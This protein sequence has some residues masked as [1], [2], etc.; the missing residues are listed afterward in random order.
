MNSLNPHFIHFKC[1]LL[2]RGFMKALTFILNFKCS[3]V[4]FKFMK[5]HLHLKPLSVFMQT[6]T[7]ESAY[8]PLT[9]ALVYIW[10]HFHFHESA[11]I[12][13]ALTFFTFYITYYV[14]IG[15]GL[16]KPCKCATFYKV[17]YVNIAGIKRMKA[18]TSGMHR[19]SRRGWKHLHFYESAYIPLRRGCPPLNAND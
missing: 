13:K 5:T 12:L 14:N 19:L 17:Y 9:Y 16:P 8:I 11:Y 10:K 6:L 1:S 18:L 15:D 3:L 7:F 2:N 4:N